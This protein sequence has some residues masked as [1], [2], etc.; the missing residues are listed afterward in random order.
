VNLNAF[1]IR[2]ASA[3]ARTWRSISTTS[4]T[5]VGATASDL[6]LLEELG[7]HH[8]LALDDLG[9]ETNAGERLVDEVANTHEAA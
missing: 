8:A 1:C 4:A 7:D 5:S 3:P 9:I 2:F 6:F